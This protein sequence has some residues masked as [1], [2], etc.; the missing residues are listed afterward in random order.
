MIIKPNQ[1]GSIIQTRKVVD[2][3]KAN[4]IITV[5]SHRSGETMDTMI[6]DL[7]VAWEIPYIKTGIHGKERECKLQRL[8]DIEGIM[9]G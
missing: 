8:A 5:I 4:D 9:H 7:A 3:A 1:I 2:F 6:A